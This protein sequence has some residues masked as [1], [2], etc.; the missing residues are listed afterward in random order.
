MEKDAIDALEDALNDLG[1]REKALKAA[2][3]AARPH[4]SSRAPAPPAEDDV[5]GT[6]E[7]RC[8]VQSLYFLLR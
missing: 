6:G 5:P 7:G 1:E 3:Q 4:L 8:S 2:L